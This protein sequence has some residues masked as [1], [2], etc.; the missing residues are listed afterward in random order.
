MAAPG[1][2][3]RDCYDCLFATPFPKTTNYQKHT[4]KRLIVA[5][6]F[7]ATLTAGAQTLKWSVGVA[8]P[9][10]WATDGHGAL[11]L[12]SNLGDPVQLASVT[13]IDQAGR[14]LFTNVVT[15]FGENIAGYNVRVVRFNSRELA[16][17]VEAS[18][19][20]A[21]GTN[22]L[23][24]FRKNGTFRDT[25]LEVGETMD[26]IP[27]TLTDDRGFFSRQGWVFRRYS[28]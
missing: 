18:Y 17:Q 10:G 23:R 16:V 7:A 6:A 20:Y 9:S 19:E 22:Y 12:I 21:P 2:S 14:P 1:S 11:A 27:S 4:M 8:N 26:A 25:V 28:N 24:R 13:W 15:G 5:L 3:A